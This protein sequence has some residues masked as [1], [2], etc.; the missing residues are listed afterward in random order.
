VSQSRD[1]RSSAFLLLDRFAVGHFG[2]A[3]FPSRPLDFF[4][5]CSF[6]RA[7]LITQVFFSRKNLCDSVFISHRDRAVGQVSALCFCLLRRSGT[8]LRSLVSV[9]ASLCIGK[10][11]F[12]SGEDFHCWLQRFCF[13]AC[14]ARLVH[15]LVLSPP[16]LVLCIRLSSLLCALALS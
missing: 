15:D 4:C 7:R 9:S 14:A 5:P 2:L 13:S 8:R 1:E 16:I 3:S 10:Y 6:L 11:A 12:L